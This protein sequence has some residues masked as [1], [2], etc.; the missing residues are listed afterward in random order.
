MVATSAVRALGSGVVFFA[1]GF[2]STSDEPFGSGA[3][4][5]GGGL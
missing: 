3:A 2:F 4:A 1:S 5:A